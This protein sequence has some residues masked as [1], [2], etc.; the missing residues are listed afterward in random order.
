VNNVPEYTAFH[1]ERDG[2]RYTTRNESDIVE[3]SYGLTGLRVVV[4]TT[5]VEENKDVFLEF[6]FAAVRGFRY[7]DEG[8]LIRYWTSGAFEH[9]YHLFRVRAGGWRDQEIATPGMMIVS[10]STENVSEWFVKTTNGCLNV[11]SS[12]APEIR[13]F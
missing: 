8:D 9:G 5:A 7:L 1:V 11:L 12:G 13:E 3:M 6:T 2:K 4:S 10:G